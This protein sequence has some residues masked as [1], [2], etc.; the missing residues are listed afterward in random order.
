MYKKLLVYSLFLKIVFVTSAYAQ[1]QNK[2]LVKVDNAIIT[3]YDLENKI[4]S[5]LHLAN[6]EVNQTNI[7]KTKNVAIQSLINLKIKQIELANFDIK[8]NE[9]E[10]VKQIDRLANGDINQFKQGFISKNLDYN[11]F[12]NEL[13]TELKWNTLIYLIYNKKVKVEESEIQDQLEKIIK[14]NSS[15]VELKLSEIQI[16]SNGDEE[17]DQQSINSIKDQIN[18]FGF[19]LTAMRNSNSVSAKQ[20]GNLGWINMKSFSRKIYEILNKMN[21]GDVSPPIISSNNILFLKIIDKRV[22]KPD[23]IDKSKLKKDLENRRKNELFTLYSNSHLSK[24]KKK[25]FIQYQ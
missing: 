23:K 11:F 14:S 16:L 1:I 18:E 2:I 22:S 8:E 17:K 12:L 5:L 25:I 4:K 3:S 7:D 9:E 24:I 10:F 20:N 6:Q 13:K 15:N 19:G 21:I